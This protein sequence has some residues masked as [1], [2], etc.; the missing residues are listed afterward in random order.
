M[1]I[2]SHILM[3]LSRSAT[4]RSNLSDQQ[5]PKQNNVNQNF[6]NDQD[7]IR[8]LAQNLRNFTDQNLISDRNSYIQDSN[9]QL[10]SRKLQDLHEHR[11]GNFGQENEMN[12]Y[13][14]NQTD[15]QQMKSRVENDDKFNLM[16]CSDDNEG[17]EQQEHQYEGDGNI[18]EEVDSAEEDNKMNSKKSYNDPHDP[19]NILSQSL[20]DLVNNQIEENNFHTGQNDE[21]NTNP[22]SHQIT[23]QNS[24]NQQNDHEM[25]EK[26]EKLYDLDT[27]RFEEEYSNLPSSK[28]RI[29]L[30]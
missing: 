7:N 6:N 5:S 26:L 17:D 13:L 25:V 15:Q 18:L 11:N 29:L 22:N 4:S 14:T 30:N 1:T 9:E 16:S 12:N 21:S 20:R 2:N 23:L 8:N 19:Q 24:T 27:S 3:S 28:K 10:T